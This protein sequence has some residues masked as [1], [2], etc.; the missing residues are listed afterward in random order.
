ML[1]YNEFLLAKQR[2]E[3]IAQAVA[4]ESAMRVDVRVNILG[5]ALNLVKSAFAQRTPT[6]PASVRRTAIAE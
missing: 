3:E 5:N 1:F 2:H 6:K 4:R